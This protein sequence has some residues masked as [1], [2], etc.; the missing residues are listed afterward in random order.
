[1]D[2]GVYQAFTSAL[3]DF[4]SPTDNTPNPSTPKPSTPKPVEA[5]R[6]AQEMYEFAMKRIIAHNGGTREEWEDIMRK[7]AYHEAGPAMNPT[8]KQIAKGGKEGPGRGLYQYEVAMSGD[9]IKGSNAGKTAVKR[10][11]NVYQEAGVKPPK[12]LAQ[13]LKDGVVE[14][15]KL[16]PTAQSAL[17]LLDKLGGPAPSKQMM[18]GDK[19]LAEFM[20]NYHYI[21]P[22]NE[23]PDYVQKFLASAAAYEAEKKAPKKK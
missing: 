15:D 22:E 19:S 21:G 9:G 7:A 17:F 20:A 5:S 2:N 10:A 12:F 18:L 13:A 11:Y 1:M 14:F 23:R 16:S 6:E 3:E 8:I 4:Q